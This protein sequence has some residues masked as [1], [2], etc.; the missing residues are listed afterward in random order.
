ML[1]Q[2]EK[3]WPKIDLISSGVLTL[4][5]MGSKS[6]YSLWG[7]IWPPHQKKPRSCRL[8]I[9]LGRITKVGLYFMMMQNLSDLTSLWRHSDVITLM[10]SSK[11]VKIKNRHNFWKNFP[12]ITIAPSFFMFWDVL[13]EKIYISDD[14]SHK[15]VTSAVFIFQVFDD[16]IMTSRDVKMS[17]VGFFSF[18]IISLIGI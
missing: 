9:K 16:V 5:P 11:S 12:L 13:L 10:T 3:R 18:W 14:W 15:S 1:Q 8:A 6:T 7:G 17:D 4:F 2:E